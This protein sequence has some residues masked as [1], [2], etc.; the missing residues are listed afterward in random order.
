MGVDWEQI[1]RFVHAAWL[2]A[3]ENGYSRAVPLRCLPGL[4]A[5]SPTCAELDA[6]GRTDQLLLSLAD[7][8]YD[9]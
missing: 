6:T 2:T 1:P 4:S 8:A 9:T 3:L 7:G 5:K